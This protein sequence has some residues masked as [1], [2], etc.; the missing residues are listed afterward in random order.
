M[1]SGAV[2]REGISPRSTI[3]SRT[4]LSRRVSIARQSLIFVGHELTV[5]HQAAERLQYE[6][7]AFFD[8]IEDL[9]SEDEIYAVDP[10]LCFL[11]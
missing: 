9:V 5:L 11:T 6:F 3:S 4:Y 10:D 2:R 1:A 7:F 8:V